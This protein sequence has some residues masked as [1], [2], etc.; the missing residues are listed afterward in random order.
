VIDTSLADEDIIE[1]VAIKLWDVAEAALDDNI[2][3][4]EIMLACISLQKTM[5]LFL[6]VETVH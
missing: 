3:P 5:G 1:A 2:S 4:E 6:E